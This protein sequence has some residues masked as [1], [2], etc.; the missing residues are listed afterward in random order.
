MYTTSDL[1]RGLVIDLDGAP[2]LV[3]MVQT[4]SPTARGAST[5]YKVKLRNLK[6]KQ[7]VD[8]SFR[9]GETFPVPDVEYRSIDFLY[10]DPTALHFMDNVSFEQFAI[11]RGELEWECKFLVEGIQGLRVVLYNDEPIGLELPN[12]ITL[13]IV[14]TLPAV[15]GGAASGRTKA[16][17]VSTGH[18]I[19]VPEHIDSNT[20]VVIDTRTGDYVGRA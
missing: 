12:T 4:S 2:H 7:R 8:R 10:E 5:I 9:G 17:T 1:K 18:V 13:E 3:E 16:A 6:T 19:Q 20:L 11:P 15:K 14:E